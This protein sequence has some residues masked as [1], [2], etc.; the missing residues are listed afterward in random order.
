MF[1]VIVGCFGQIMFDRGKGDGNE[2]NFGCK[3]QYALQFRCERSLVTRKNFSRESSC[4]R[5]IN[6]KL[7]I[8]GDKLEVRN[9]K[10]LVKMSAT[11]IKNIEV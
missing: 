8:N 3:L 4:K 10:V 9:C 2:L 6:L 5:N 7:F 11:Y 1:K